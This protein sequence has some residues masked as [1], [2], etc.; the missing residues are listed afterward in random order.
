M[1]INVYTHIWMNGKQTSY[2]MMAGYILFSYYTPWCGVDDD[3]TCENSL[4]KT[5]AV[6]FIFKND[7]R[8]ER[9][10]V[11]SLDGNWKDLGNVKDVTW[12]KGVYQI[13]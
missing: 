6:K 12:F 13:I 9:I 10:K 8:S 4:I 5:C 2:T 7:K 1:S 11:C 3:K